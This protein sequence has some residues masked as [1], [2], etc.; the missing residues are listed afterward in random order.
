MPR[1]QSK[2]CQSN[3][4]D[5]R[6]G[7]R[8]VLVSFTVLAATTAAQAAIFLLTGSVALLT[9][10]IHNAGDALTAVPLGISFVLPSRRASRVAELLVLGA[11][12]VSAAVAGVEAIRRLTIARAPDRLLVLAAGGVVG[13][14]GNWIAAQ[15]RTRTGRAIGNAALM[16]DGDHALI[17]AFVS[18]AVVASALLLYL[19]FPIADPLI[20]LASVVVI[21]LITIRAWRTIQSG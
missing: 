15:V 6:K 9:D 10:L 17:D 13:A 12:I 21:V 8:A 18:L 11:I 14:I 2:K 5:A 19:G 4:L 20:G 16:A 3:D 7:L 1:T